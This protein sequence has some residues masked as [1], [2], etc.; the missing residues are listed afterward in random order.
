MKMCDGI[1][2]S[3]YPFRDPSVLHYPGHLSHEDI[4]VM[5]AADGGFDKDD[6]SVPQYNLRSH[7]APVHDT[8][9]HDASIERRQQVDASNVIGDANAP[10]GQTRAR[11]H[12]SPQLAAVVRLHLPLKSILPLLWSRAKIIGVGLSACMYQFTPNWN[13][14]QISN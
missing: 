11:T 1:F 7:A 3:T 4:C 10:Q 6:V 12:Q 2:Y 5:H 9:I 8:P 14:C 13:Y